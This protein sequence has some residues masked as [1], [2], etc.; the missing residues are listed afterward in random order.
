M[1]KRSTREGVA[2][3]AEAADAK[4][5]LDAFMAKFSPEIAAH[6]KATLREMRKLYPTALELVYDN[7]NA[8]AIGFA[9]SERASEAI[10]S[11]ALYP[12]WVSLFF[13]QGAGLADPKGMLK[14]SGKVVRYIVL[15]SP[16]MVHDPDVQALMR[17]AVKEAR[18]PFDPTG[19]HRLIIK[20]VS[21]KQRP[22][23]PAAAFTA[24]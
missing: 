8:L 20:S 18:V 3:K 6:A 24:R 4:A 1:E 22:R 13:L 15:S 5:Q 23:Q 17:S 2:S 14:G 21:K 19:K 11:I 7:Y 16:Q 10:F 12:K 9:P